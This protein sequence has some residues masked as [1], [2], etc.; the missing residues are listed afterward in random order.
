MDHIYI[1]L[2]IIF[3]V[4]GQLILKWQMLQVGPLP[5]NGADKVFFLL[6]LFLNPWVLSGFASAFVAAMSWMVAMTKF[7][8]SYAY[9][10]TG[11]VFALLLLFS[12]LLFHETVTMPKLIGTVLIVLGVVVAS[13]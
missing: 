13:Q 7:P 4:Y 11:L 9:P 6:R 1:F 3:T 5:A 8:L 10:Y 2:T 12:S